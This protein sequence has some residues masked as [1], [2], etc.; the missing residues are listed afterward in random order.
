MNSYI[1]LLFLQFSFLQKLFFKLNATY[2]LKKVL[3]LSEE[4]NFQNCLEVVILLKT[5]CKILSLCVELG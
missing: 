4:V 2:V 5:E 3:V 1:S